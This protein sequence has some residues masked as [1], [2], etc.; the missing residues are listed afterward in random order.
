[1]SKLVERL[2]AL[3]FWNYYGEKEEEGIVYSLKQE[4]CH[5]IACLYRKRKDF[6]DL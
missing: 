6:P 2:D 5:L 3:S 4:T 1:M